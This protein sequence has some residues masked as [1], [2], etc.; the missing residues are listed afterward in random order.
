MKKSLLAGAL[1]AALVFVF[2]APLAYAANAV[3]DDEKKQC[4]QYDKQSVTLSGTVLVRKIHYDNSND[5]PPEGSVP[6]PLL[7]LDQ[8]ICAWGPDNE[9]ESLQ[10]ALQI[11]DECARTWPTVSRIK[12][13]GTLYHIENWHQHSLVLVSAKQLVRLDGR[14]PACVGN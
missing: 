5:A 1:V 13:T 4:V 6:F 3:T 11:A 9:S 10:S 12:V 7:V 2:G 14:L 8:P